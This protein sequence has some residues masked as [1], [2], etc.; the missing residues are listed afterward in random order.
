MAS[1][2]L[3][4]LAGSILAIQKQTK[5][6]PAPVIAAA[7]R[8]LQGGGTVSDAQLM[9]QFAGVRKTGAGAVKAQVRS[10]NK[11]AQKIG[12]Y[13][14]S[15]GAI[16]QGG[17]VGMG[18][19]IGLGSQ[20]GYDMQTLSE[21]PAVRRAFIQIAERIKAG[22][23]LG[24]IS[25]MAMGQMGKNL[26]MLSAVAEVGVN[27]AEFQINTMAALNG[28]VNYEKLRMLGSGAVLANV[29]P[30]NSPTARKI[31]QQRAQSQLIR[32][33]GPGAIPVF[34]ELIARGIELSANLEAR[35]K[36]QKKLTLSPG[37]IE[38]LALRDA[39]QK[40]GVSSSLNANAQWGQAATRYYSKQSSNE[41]IA[42]ASKVWGKLFGLSLETAAAI[43]AE[44]ESTLSRSKT[45][46][47]DFHKAAEQKRF[48]LAETYKK[49]ANLELAGAVP[50]SIDA[51]TWYRV[52]ESG[53]FAERS[54]AYSQMPRAGMREH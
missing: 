39:I 45:L 42:M 5:A 26:G 6:V 48:D 15:I 23:N 33:V 37:D 16:A 10:F 29:D 36:G 50:A 20:V 52:A 53:R 54:W 43:R 27:A 8:T 44:G 13:A 51:G 4:G 38:K 30:L 25:Y 17:M 3:K 40:S 35:L 49:E 21:N 31:E 11:F 47:D 1:S 34:G 41:T 22:K 28:N 7:R 14:N 24:Q 32:S 12:G 2:G 9:R 19:M 46:S 18:G